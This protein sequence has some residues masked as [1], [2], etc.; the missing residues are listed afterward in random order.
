[1][2]YFFIA[3]VSAATL[4][5]A[6]AA[7]D[8]NPDFS[9]IWICDPRRSE[10]NLS[11]PAHL[12]EINMSIGVKVQGP[13]ENGGKILPN[14]PP[15]SRMK[16]LILQISQSDDTLQIRRT[17]NLDGEKQT[18]TQSFLLDG[19]RNINMGSGGEGEFVSRSSWK[20]KK[21]ILDGTN[22]VMNPEGEE[23]V[24]IH[25]EY[26]LSK[27]G[28]RLTIKIRRISQRGTVKIKQVFDRMDPDPEADAELVP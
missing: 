2:R 28:K 16:D 4:A 1:M 17:F 8:K 10:T 27:K 7:G 20:K 22:T 19:S 5:C 9:G 24:Y 11:E 6:F 3:V 15:E 14:S 23:E 12:P 18:F 21:L 13:D 25:E 26:A